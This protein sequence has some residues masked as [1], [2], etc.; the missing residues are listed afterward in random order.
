[1]R[2]IALTAALAL[3]AASQA[4]PAD[5]VK[6]GV[7]LSVTGSFG[8]RGLARWNGI[9]IAEEMSRGEAG[10][11]VKVV[12]A[13]SRSDGFDSVKAML[14]LIEVEEVTAII[15]ELGPGYTAAGSFCARRKR[16]PLIA[17]YVPRSVTR[18]ENL[19]FEVRPVGPNQGR[20]AARFVAQRLNARTAA[21]L[22]DISDEQSMEAARD[23]REEFTSTGGSTIAE[24]RLK[25]GDRDFSGQLSQI[26]K[27]RPDLVFA[28]VSH[29]ECALFARQARDFG[30]SVPLVAGDAIHAPGF[31]ALGGRSVEGVYGVATG[32][33]RQTLTKDGV[34]FSRRF[35][36]A[37][38]THPSPDAVG[39]AEA[40]FM[41]LEA[42]QRAG[43]ADPE[44]IREAL[45]SARNVLRLTA[46]VPSGADSLSTPV[47]AALRVKGGKITRLDD[48]LKRAAGPGE[49]GG[50]T[51]LLRV[52]ELSA[53]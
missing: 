43:S 12:L 11:P 52:Q 33:E 41:V 53:Q 22:Y 24:L 4:W 19:V 29:V 2:K 17:P 26:R 34:E 30:M 47:V 20:I 51:F 18:A 10:L 28:P 15:G 23:F 39:G 3:L 32:A 7:W 46:T 35:R 44:R 6:V 50:K 1:M 38:G 25:R 13:D 5:P 45:S 49:I 42:V 37:F 40:Y 31:L 8:E 36:E 48:D 9:R 14:R 16:I 21:V 27:S